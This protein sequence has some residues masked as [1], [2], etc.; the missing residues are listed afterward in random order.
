[1]RSKA[2]AGQTRKR[3]DPAV[4]AG[5]ILNV[6]LKLFA[7]RHYSTVSMRDIAEA[8]GINA[9][10]I[11]YY[12]ENKGELLRRSLSHAMA[13]LQAGYEARPT[14]NP[15]QELTAWLKAHIPIAP[16]LIHMVENHVGLRRRQ[17]QDDEKVE[18]MIRDFYARR[19]KFPGKLPEPRHRPKPVP[20]TE[21]HAD[22]PR[23]QPA[24]RRHFLRLPGARRQPHHPGPGKPVH[25]CHQPDAQGQEIAARYA[26][27]PP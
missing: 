17:H 10:L 2:T 24:A 15:A 13:E 9:G 27:Q 16:M 19:T 26:R 4:R 8:C 3:L 1:M 6:A 12:Y 25:H 14:L 22:R 11:Y 21:R 5:H 7:E 23:H 20:Q 18:R